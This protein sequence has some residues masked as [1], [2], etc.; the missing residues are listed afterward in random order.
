MPWLTA[1]YN[2]MRFTQAR[3]KHNAS[4]P[5]ILSTYTNHLGFSPR[6]LGV[7]F[8]KK[9]CWLLYFQ[10]IKYKLAYQ[11]NVLTRLTA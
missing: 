8:H 4:F 11:I 9:L 1:S 3:T 2:L 6:V 5:L 10:H 7:I